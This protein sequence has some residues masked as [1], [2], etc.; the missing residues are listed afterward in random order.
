MGKQYYPS[1][2]TEGCLFMEKYCYKCYKEKQ[3]RI[4]TNSLIGKHPKQWIIN[5]RNVP[6]C[7]SFNPNKPK[8]K[9]K[10]KSNNLPNLFK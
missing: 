5:E 2:G 1:N 7:T 8:Q 9:K 6:T 10:V 3:C 4:L